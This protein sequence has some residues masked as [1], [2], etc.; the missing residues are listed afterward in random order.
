MCQIPS[1]V[2]ID[3][4]SCKTAHATAW[5]KIQQKKK[6]HRRRCLILE[7]YLKKGNRWET[8]NKKKENSEKNLYLV[9]HPSNQ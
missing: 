4:K 7:N 1:S 6:T 2:K 3:V 9:P 5:Q 8:Y